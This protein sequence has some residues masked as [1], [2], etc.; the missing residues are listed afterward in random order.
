MWKWC[1]HTNKVI[2]DRIFVKLAGNQYRHKVSDEFDVQPGLTSHFGVMCPLA[3]KNYAYTYIFK[4]E[5]LWDQLAS[6]GQI[7]CVA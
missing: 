3:P 2:I 6:L 1:L 7:L 5:Y 4:H